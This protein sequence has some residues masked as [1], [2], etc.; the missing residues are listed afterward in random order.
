MF[1]A[2]SG[3]SG[4]LARAAEMR[5]SVRSGSR[6][7]R[8]SLQSMRRS[9]AP[10]P[11][12][13]IGCPLGSPSPSALA[14]FTRAPANAWNGQPLSWH[15]RRYL[16]SGNWECQVH[17][18]GRTNHVYFN[19][20]ETMADYRLDRLMIEFHRIPRQWLKAAEHQLQERPS[21]PDSKSDPEKAQQPVETGHRRPTPRQ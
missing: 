13:S 3:S 6:T 20:H 5:G 9:Q 7:S 15:R 1:G 8:S 17:L 16:D 2:L 11:H 14:G 12:G 18:D 19:A 21:S 10:G 4:S